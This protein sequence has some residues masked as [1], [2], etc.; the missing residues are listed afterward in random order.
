[1]AKKGTASAF[2][3]LD[4]SQFEQASKAA[5]KIASGSGKIISTA[6]GTALGVLSGGAALGALTKL[7]GALAGAA[8]A[9]ARLARRMTD[10]TAETGLSADA[11][12]RFQFAIENG[13]TQA[14]SARLLGDA[15]K[16]I[17]E[18]A[19]QFR[20]VHIRMSAIAQRI[21]AAAASLSAQ[22]MPIID[23]ILDLVEEIDWQGWA[24]QAA[25]A[26]RPVSDVVLGIVE[27]IRDDTL[28]ENAGL[29]LEFGIAKAANVLN[30]AWEV[31]KVAVV[32]L[33]PLLKAAFVDGIPALGADLLDVAAN[34]ADAIEDAMVGGANALISSTITAIGMLG[35][36]KGVSA[37]LGKDFERFSQMARDGEI[38]ASV[39]YS[40]GTG[41]KL[42]ERGANLR[43]GHEGGMT[44]ALE[45]FIDRLKDVEMA[46]I[47][48]SG[49][50]LQELTDNLHEA[51]VKAERRGSSD[52]DL[53]D[54]RGRS[55]VF[56]SVDSLQAVGG[57]GGIGTGMS[58][59][60]DEQKTAN[61]HLE[62][63]AD[64]IG[65]RG[66]N[67]L[68]MPSFGPSTFSQLSL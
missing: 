25:E 37:V 34:F 3:S 60:V 55:G 10:I 19:N 53:E 8:T 28:W 52:N 57:G 59:M 62:T 12:M 13:L 22:A 48:G 66:P 32:A 15:G 27:M 68:Q 35:E 42:R 45:N 46:D 2:L 54:V 33:G 20:S 38:S 36:M 40:S 61:R 16:S 31:S 23:S 43:E 41:D 4:I 14:D 5:Q 51:I 17:E 39:G 6:F 30:H 65:S 58:T 29:L 9:G 18:S 11:A 50:I 24:D 7:P 64:L 21:Q 56:G 63:I 67:T 47:F 44:R 49:E 26:L 1:M